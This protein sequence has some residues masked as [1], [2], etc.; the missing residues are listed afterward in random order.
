MCVRVG[1]RLS[2]LVDYNCDGRQGC[3][4]LL[5]FF[6]IFINILLEGVK[7]I[8]ITGKHG[9]STNSPKK[10]NC[11]FHECRDAKNQV[12]YGIMRIKSRSGMF[13]A[14]MGK[15]IAQISSHKFLFLVFN[16]MWNNF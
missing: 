7:G 2:K 3:P 14:I 16:N 13:F 8:K 10:S 4:E 9:G 6:E 5:L 11:I 1:Y 12:K 15:P